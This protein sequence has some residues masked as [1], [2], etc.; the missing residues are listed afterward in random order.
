M[1]KKI[2]RIIIVA[3][4][5]TILWFSGYA[6]AQKSFFIWDEG[7]VAGA[8]DEKISIAFT[9]L[10]PNQNLEGTLESVSFPDDSYIVVEDVQVSKMET[11]YQW[12]RFYGIILNIRLK[13]PGEM[14][15]DSVILHYTNGTEEKYVLG[16]WVYDIGTADDEEINTWESV[17]ASSSSTEFAYDYICEKDGIDSCQIYTGIADP[18][19]AERK[20][21]ETFSGTIDISKSEAPLKYVRSKIVYEKDG[22]EKVTYGKGCY[23]G[24]MGL[25]KEGIELSRKHNQ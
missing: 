7:Y 17:A 10:T 2:I 22:Q 21:N 25:T 20:N 11:R 19:D 14:K 4:F 13:E 3:C 16:D 24:G 9:F 1:R 12:Y 8:V 23:C 6:H 5:G 18:A 15:T